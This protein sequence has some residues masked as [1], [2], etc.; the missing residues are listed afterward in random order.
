MLKE[1]GHVLNARLEN[2]F[3]PLNVRTLFRELV[4]NGKELLVNR[5][6]KEVE[7][8]Y[9][10]SKEY[11]ES[12]SKNV[13]PFEPISFMALDN[14]LEWPQIEKSLDYFQSKN[15]VIDDSKLFDQFC[16][17][18]MILTSKLDD[19]NFTELPIHKRWVEFFAVTAVKEKYYEFFKLTQFTFSLF[20]HNAA[21]ERIF[22]LVA[23]QW[24]KERNRFNVETIN[25]II[26]TIFNT[27]MQCDQF[28]Q[29]LL[30]NPNL[31]KQI[32]SNEKYL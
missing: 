22:S 11:I 21:V 7:E 32:C 8:M 25:G 15:I 20:G 28:Y 16:I 23:G 24:T 18:K 6:K 1:V 30:S 19:P 5:V 14:T 29:Y 13:E 17:L 12:W 31:I 9:R 4:E 3:L 10:E 26:V 27:D 2:N